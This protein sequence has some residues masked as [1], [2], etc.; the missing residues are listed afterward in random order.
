MEAQTKQ[1]VA[2]VLHPPGDRRRL[3]LVQ[4]PDVPGE[5]LPG[6]WGLPAAS[7]GPGETEEQ[8]ARRVGWQKLGCGVRLLRVLGRGTGD[9][10]GYRLRMTVY[11]AETELPAIQLPA[12]GVDGATYYVAWRWG[13]LHDLHEAVARGSLCARVALHALI[14][15][16]GYSASP[17][18]KASAE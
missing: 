13:C 5:E 11:E 15:L 16:P 12:P 17:T 14:Q 3:L 7:L 6:V 9:R 1:A 10:L 4:R 2:L 18:S 8:A